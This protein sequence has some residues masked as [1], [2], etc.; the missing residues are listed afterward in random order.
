MSYYDIDAI[1]TDAQ[2]LPCTFNLS[3]PHLTHLDPTTPGPLRSGTRLDL[4]LWLSIM[5]AV[6]AP[7]PSQMPGQPSSLV[8]LDL[9]DSLSPRVLNALKADARS[10]DLRVLDPYFYAL[11]ARI[12]ELFEE[13]E[14]CEVLLESFRARAEGIRDFA[15]NTGG[16]GAAS[17]G[18]AKGLGIDGVEFLRGLDEME[19][20]LFKAA[21]E[22]SKGVKSWLGEARKR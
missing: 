14:V 3:V 10:V 1:L 6:S 8:T 16:G 17:G 2:K 21:H 13:D 18:G 15:G 5:L 19:R 7:S 12:L 22:G 4:P 11:G 20:G 9:P